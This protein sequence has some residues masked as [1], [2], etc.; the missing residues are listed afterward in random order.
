MCEKEEKEGRRNLC[1]CGFPFM[2][3]THVSRLITDVLLFL[4]IA[5]C[6]VVPLSVCVLCSSFSLIFARN[7]RE[8]TTPVLLSSKS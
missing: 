2:I 6:F 4:I 8:G 7:Q 5:V 3:Q 1:H